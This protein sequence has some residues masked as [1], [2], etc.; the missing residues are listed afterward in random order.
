MSESSAEVVGVVEAFAE[1][2]NRHDMAS[3][4]EVF[5]EDAEFVNV[6]GLWWRGR[7]EIR[8]AHEFTHGTIFKHSRITVVENRVR[9]LS[10]D[11]ATV[12]SRWTLEGHVSPD[13]AP[14]PAR[15]G[16]M[17]NVVRRDGERWRVVESQNTNVVEGELSRP[18]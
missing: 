12:R 16:V 5:A 2:W 18:Q 11:L 4:A 3:F 9:A 1:S 8:R 14:L 13:G 17:L 6:V 7:D 15:H 10:D